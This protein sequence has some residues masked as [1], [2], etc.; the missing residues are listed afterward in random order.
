M[1]SLFLSY[2][3]NNVRCPYCNSSF[4]AVWSGEPEVGE[5]KK[6]CLACEKVFL[7]EV[8]VEY[9]TY[10]IVKENNNPATKPPI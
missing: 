6:Q 8:R 1:C 7:V 2:D 4:A 5:F 9:T 3:G 10:P